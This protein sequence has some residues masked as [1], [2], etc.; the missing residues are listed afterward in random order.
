VLDLK[1]IGVTNAAALVG[2]WNSWQA[3]KLPVEVTKAK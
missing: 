1:N 2:G 3:A